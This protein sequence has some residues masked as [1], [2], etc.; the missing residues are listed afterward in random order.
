MAGPVHG[1]PAPRPTPPNAL[2][3]EERAEILAVL[4]SPAYA[5]LAVA[6][7]WAM[8]LDDGTYLASQSTMHRVL[9]E[10]GE[11]RDR[12]RQ[13]THPA[14]KKPHLV[15][16]RPLS[17]VELGHHQTARPRPGRLLRLLRDHRH[18]QPLRRGLDGGGL[19]DS[20]SPRPS[21][22]TPSP[23]RA[24]AGTSSPSTPTGARR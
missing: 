18:L 24:W 13:R 7:V 8:L 11:S 6:Q 21:S 3:E 16:H 9:R 12:R 20:S 22:P 10:L 23:D 14:K 15:A 1:P 2:S 5:D 4:R 19:E 17:S